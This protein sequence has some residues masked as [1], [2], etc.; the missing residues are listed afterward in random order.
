MA[1]YVNISSDGSKSRYPDNNAEHFISPLNKPITLGCEYDVALYHFS[2]YY[3]NPS[4]SIAEEADEKEKISYIKVQ[5][6]YPPYT[7]TDK[8]VL[9]DLW[10]K[11]LDATDIAHKYASYA[12]CD[13]MLCNDI[14]I[15]IFI[16]GAI[17]NECGGY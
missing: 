4:D 15:S 10:Q 16:N 2:K 9:Q 3:D 13:S 8:A 1:F 6:A 7:I 11:Y 12:L 17:A 14:S 5:A